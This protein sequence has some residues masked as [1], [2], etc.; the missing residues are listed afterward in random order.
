LDK[1]VEKATLNLSLGSASTEL[2]YASAILANFQA[3][4]FLI[5]IMSWQ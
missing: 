1:E 5:L 2:Q 4:L 3:W